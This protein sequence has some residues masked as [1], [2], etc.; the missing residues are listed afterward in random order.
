MTDAQVKEYLRNT[1]AGRK[2]DPG[3]AAV[4]LLLERQTEIV[5]NELMARG[6][7]APD[8]DWLAG[9][10]WYLTAVAEELAVL[11]QPATETPPTDVT[12]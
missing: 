6:T 3:I 7:P 11:T 12:P 1:L 10:K 2:N 4:Q 8:R 9:A 5:D